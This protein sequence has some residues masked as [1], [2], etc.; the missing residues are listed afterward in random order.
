MVASELWSAR[1]SGGPIPK[2]VPV[3]VLE[4][5]G[6]TAVVEATISIPVEESTALGD[7]AVREG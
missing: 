5:D 7:G 2:G 3:R 4:M 6:M 1:S